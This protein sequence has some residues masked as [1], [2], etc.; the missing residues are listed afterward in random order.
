MREVLDFFGRSSS[1]RSLVSLIGSPNDEEDFVAFTPKNINDILS[2]IE[3]SISLFDVKKTYSRIIDIMGGLPTEFKKIF[4]ISVDDARNVFSFDKFKEEIKAKLPI[5]ELVLDVAESELET[6]KRELSQL[7]IKI[8]S[9]E[10]SESLTTIQG[11]TRVFKFTNELILSVLYSQDAKTFEKIKRIHDRIDEERFAQ[12]EDTLDTAVSEIR[13][14]IEQ[15][16]QEQKEIPK[17]TSSFWGV[18]AGAKSDTKTAKE[19]IEPIT[20]TSTVPT[21]SFDTISTL[22]GYRSK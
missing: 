15:Q 5:F 11:I 18:S 17:E 13:D 7:S 1:E 6:A 21:E 12:E 9:D 8:P 16:V 14:E 2:I 10:G 22:R 19:A 3:D 4:L 20:A